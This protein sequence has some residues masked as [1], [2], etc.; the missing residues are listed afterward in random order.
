MCLDARR[1]AFLR[2]LPKAEHHCHIEG[3]LTPALLFDL[4]VRNNIQLPSSDPAFASKETLLERYDRFT[5]LDDFLHFYYI[6]MSALM[7]QNDFDDLAWAYFQTAA[8]DGVVHAEISFDPQAHIS[9][10]VPFSYVIDG[11]TAACRR[12]QEELGMSTNLICC[13]LRHLPSQAA[14]DLLD[15]EEF[16]AAVASGKITGIGLDSSEKDFPPELFVDV[17]VK[18]KALGLRLT[19]HA[20]EEGPAENVEKALSL[21]CCE[22]I[23]H[24]IRLA[25]RPDLVREVAR[26]GT[27]LTICPLSNVR[28]RCARSVAELPIKIFV[29]AGIQFSINSDDPSYFGGFILANYC[30]VNEAFNFDTDTW[31]QIC[32]TAIQGSWCSQERKNELLANLANLDEQ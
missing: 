27:M 7:E 17:F 22:R 4:S 6:A 25:D 26:R 24:G 14:A 10:G 18:A 2:A 5:S 31:I 11:L 13:F 16:K 3:T 30:A 28:L 32:S 1:H 15:K 8:A 20:G 12:A 9:R 29:D 19:A 23:D 21:L